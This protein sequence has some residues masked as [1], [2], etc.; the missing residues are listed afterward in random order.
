ME[1]KHR[2]KELRKEYNM[3]QKELGAAIGMGATAIA[4]YESGKNKPA[5]C[6]LHAMAD[7]FHV[8]MDYLIGY[9]DI[10]YPYLSDVSKED[11]NLFGMYTNLSQKNKDHLRS[12]T[13]FVNHLSDLQE[14]Q[15]EMVQTI[16]LETIAKEPV[17]FRDR[18]RELRCEQNMSQASLAAEIGY[19]PATIAGYETGRTQPAIEVL[20]IFA[21]VLHVSVDY[22]TGRSNIRNPY[23]N[24]QITAE[25]KIFLNTYL[26][27][28]EQNK[29]H[30]RAYTGYLSFLEL[31]PQE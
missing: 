18:L 25:D 13:G 20:R 1:F 19:N 7:I 12:Y 24:E 9:S 5:I 4:N 30:L 22:L 8:S 26:Q 11:E 29:I 14:K 28:P 10:R 21:E 23:M 17:A 6:V 15:K 16:P 3:K 27:L 31:V 2:L